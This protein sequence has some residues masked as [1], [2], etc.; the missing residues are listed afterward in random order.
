ME[1]FCLEAILA[2][3]VLLVLVCISIRVIIIAPY[4]KLGYIYK[5]TRISR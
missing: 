3:P 2:D 5:S 4:P 1:H